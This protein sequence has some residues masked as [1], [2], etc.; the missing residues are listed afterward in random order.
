MMIGRAIL[1]SIAHPALPSSASILA[2]VP[3]CRSSSGARTRR[4]LRVSPTI[5]SS[6]SRI[7][8]AAS[9][10][11]RGTKTSTV[12]LS[13]MR[14]SASASAPTTRDDGLLLSSNSARAPARMASVS[15]RPRA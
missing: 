8:S 15:S 9:C 2:R 13:A 7:R 1:G 3:A 14:Y 12:V 5:G 6:P 10:V 11:S 4:P